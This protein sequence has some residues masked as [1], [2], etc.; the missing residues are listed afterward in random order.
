VAIVYTVV[1][2]FVLVMPPNELAG[3]T[4][5]GVL[6]VLTVLYLTLVKRRFSGPKW[7]REA[8]QA[9]AREE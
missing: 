6:A 9:S 7:A 8:L 4:L 1:I 2:A 3:Q 5:A